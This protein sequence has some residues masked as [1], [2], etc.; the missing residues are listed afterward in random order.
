MEHRFL[1]IILTSFGPDISHTVVRLFTP[2]SRKFIPCRL[3]KKSCFMIVLLCR[4]SHHVRGNQLYTF[5]PR[6][7]PVVR[8]RWYKVT[9]FTLH[10]KPWNKPT[11]TS[12]SIECKT[13][14]L[15]TFVW[16]HLVFQCTNP[17]TIINFPNILNSDEF[18]I[19]IL[20]DTE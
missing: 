20:P 2:L 10:P 11:R 19:D 13:P 15:P 14:K 6:R 12:L 4:L 8:D 18:H 17:V 1:D 5:C 3:G 16:M 7:C 9:S